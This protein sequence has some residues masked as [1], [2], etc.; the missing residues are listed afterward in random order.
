MY[1]ILKRP[2][3]AMV[4][5]IFSIVVMG[6]V[7]MSAP[8]L[9]DT[10]TK[11]ST[12]ALQQAAIHEAVSR[13]SMILTYAWDQNDT[14]ASCTPPVLHTVDGDSELDMV[15]GTSRRVGIPMSS[16]YHTFM[17]DGVNNFNASSVLRKEGT[18]VDDMDDFIST[19]IL[20]EH[21]SGTG[22]QDYIETGTVSIDT[23]V[24]YS[25]DDASYAAS[26]VNFDFNATNISANSTSIKTI[27]VTIT[28]T[29]PH[30]ELQKKI[31]LRAFSCNIGGY[32]FERRTF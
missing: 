28:S 30:D 26:S 16:N 1:L 18:D 5:L 32:G 23:K 10:A 29:S 31:V 27:G 14:N 25:T 6:I 13:V 24:Y 21:L 19:T 17:C 7:M 2:A 22:G 11:S 9:I 20:K 3:V 8:L 12:V 4:E 15:A